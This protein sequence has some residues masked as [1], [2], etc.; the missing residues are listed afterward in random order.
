M[1]ELVV[2]VFVSVLA[3]LVVMF[4]IDEHRRKVR[5]KE[6]IDARQHDKDDRVVL[7]DII[8]EFPLACEGT[9]YSTHSHKW[10]CECNNEYLILNWCRSDE[11]S[12]I[13][14]LDIYTP[15]QEHLRNQTIRKWYIKN[16]TGRDSL[17][18]NQEVIE[19]VREYIYAHLIGKG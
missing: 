11:S 2:G 3:V 12:Q 16:T 13:T 5:E 15:S 4:G 14:D 7:V 9:F 8:S 18:Y 10:Y 19:R 1:L 17:D 6:V